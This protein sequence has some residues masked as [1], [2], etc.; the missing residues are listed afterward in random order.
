MGHKEFIT[1]C[2]K[3]NIGTN[4]SFNLYAEM[5][6]G[7]QHVGATAVD[8]KNHKREI[9]AYIKGRDAQLVIE[10]CLN[11]KEIL[12]QFYF[13][14]AVD[15]KERL[16]R[17]FWT[18][19]YGRKSFDLFGDAMA[20]DATYKTNIY[21]NFKVYNL[22]FVPFTGV[23]NHKKSTTFAWGLI[24]NEDIESYTWLLANFKLAMGREPICTTTDQ[25][26]SMKVAV[27]RVFPT[28]RHRYCMWH[29]MS[30]VSEKA[31]SELAKKDG[32]RRRLNG[33]VWNEN[34][35][36]EEFETDWRAF[37][38]EHG[39]DEHRWFSLLFEQRASWIPAYFRDVYMGG[40]LRTTSRAESQNH[41]FRS[42]TSK[43]SNL[44]ELLDKIE[45][46]IGKQRHKQTELN[47]ACDGYAPTLKTPLNLERQAAEAYTINI[48][49]EV[50]REICGSCFACKVGECTDMGGLVQ[51]MVEDGS[52]RRQMV[53]LDINQGTIECT[54]RMYTRIGLLCRHMYAALKHAGI[55]QVPTEYI[56][57][58]WTRNARIKIGANVETARDEESAHEEAKVRKTFL[59]C[60]CLAKGRTDRL[61]Q[62]AQIL[63][64][65]EKSFI[66]EDTMQKDLVEQS[67]PPQ[68][69]YDRGGPS[70]TTIHC[71]KVAKNKGSGK[72]LKSVKEIAVEKT[73][74]QRARMRDVWQK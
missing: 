26:A 67:N 61:Q 28:T 57:T 35:S 32:F 38:Q 23:D 31:G 30:K 18:D 9:L 43:H 53:E 62:L 17:V 2:A 1:K 68:E 34:A 20:F 19:E 7:V 21:G 69:F 25:D 39:L 33:I 10:K 58:R 15:E 37:T 74:K 50:Q 54:C 63:N 55:D 46:A 72:R 8:F 70:T 52:D 4:N 49:Y 64:E 48:F 3:A 51:Y 12:P 41:V 11:R 27:A 40:L 47:A 13:E 73:A 24:A 5:V 6:V 14:Y 56:K 16:S 42:C 29:I 59:N 65:K 45:G 22:V 36:I 66:N 71:P 60:I 44:M